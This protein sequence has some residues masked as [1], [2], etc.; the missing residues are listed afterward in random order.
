MCLV[1]LVC[2]SLCLSFCH[3]DGIVTESSVRSYKVMYVCMQLSPEAY[4][5]PRSNPLH[6]GDDADYDPDG[7]AEVCSL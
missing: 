7:A 1:V 5:E 3:S 2:L 6:F 4:L